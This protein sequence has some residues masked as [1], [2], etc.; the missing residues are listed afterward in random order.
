MIN[1]ARMKKVFSL[2]YA[3]VCYAA[4]VLALLYWIASTGNLLPEISI[5]GEATMSSGKAVLKNVLLVLLFGVQHTVMARQRFKQWLTRF[6]PTH[7]E[8]STYVLATGIVLFLLVSQWE[9]LGGVIWSVTANSALYYFLYGLYFAGWTILFVSTF[10]INHFDLLGLRQAYLY[11]VEMPYENV[12]FR[13]VFLYKYVRH[14]LYFGMLVGIWA[15]PL[16]TV[17]HL[18]YALLITAYIYVGIYF[19][20]RDLSAQFGDTYRSYKASTPTVIPLRFNKAGAEGR[21]PS[22]ST[23]E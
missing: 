22:M 8:R 20:E 3:I 5:D 6:I 14:P 13:I 16:M 10:L 23:D 9:P 7:L 18:V 15:T 11:A 4:G 2:I 17:T 19:E 21:K 12:K 1:N